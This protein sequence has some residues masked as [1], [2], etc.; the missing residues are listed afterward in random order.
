M[1][2]RRKTTKGKPAKTAVRRKTTK[3]KPAQEVS[4]CLG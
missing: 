1:A 4:E 2:V 3:G